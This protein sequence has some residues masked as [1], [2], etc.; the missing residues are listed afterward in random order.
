MPA[1]STPRPAD[2]GAL[3]QSPP[4]VRV[5]IAL[6][7]TLAVLLLL[8]VTVTWL[9]RDGLVQALTD[10]GLTPAEAEQ[11]LVINTAAPLVMGLVYGIAAFGVSRR[12]SWGRWTGLVAA[13][14]LAGLVAT[15][16]LT[17]GGVTVV[18]LLLFVLAVATA[19]SLL[20]RTT[21]EW[22]AAR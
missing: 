1:S 11:F 14:V 21:R 13:V 7:S 19:T 6:L 15:T 5:A 17:A 3:P 4:S 10:S 20:A 2:S 22:L 18:S 16:M 8:Y 12:R 9:G